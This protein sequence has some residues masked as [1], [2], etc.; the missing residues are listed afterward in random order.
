M[1]KSRS[2]SLPQNLF[3]KLGE[4]GQ[5]AGHSATG[6]GGQVQCLGQGNEAN[7]QMLQFLERRKEI[8]NRP[9]PAIQPPHQHDI[10]LPAAGGLQQLLAQFSLCRPGIYFADLHGDAPAAP[11]GILTHRPVLHRESLLVIRGNTGI[12]ACSQHF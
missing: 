8:C 4:D 11:G 6:W 12:E 10:N 3:F 7:A 5:Q 2:G 1:S 9:P